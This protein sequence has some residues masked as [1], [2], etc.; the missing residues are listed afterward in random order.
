MLFRSPTPPEGFEW[1][2]DS[3]YTKTV[4][5][6][7]GNWSECISV[8]KTDNNGRD[9]FYYIKKVTET[10]IPEGTEATIGTNLVGQTSSNKALT[11]TNNLPLGTLIITK[12]VTVDGQSTAGTL[13]DGTYTFQIWNADGTSQITTKNDD[14]AIGSLLIVVKNGVAS[15][16]SITVDGL[17]PGTY[18]IKETDSTNANTMI[19]TS[20]TGYDTAKGGIVVTVTGNTNIPTAAFTNNYETI[21]ATVNKTW[22]GN[23]TPPSSLKVALVA[24]G[25]ITTP[26][27]EVTLSDSNG[28]SDTITGLP[29][30][31]NGTEIV[32]TWL[33][34]D[35][36]DGYF[37]TGSSVNGTVTALTNTYQTYGLKTSYVGIKTWSD[38]NN[39][40]STRPNDLTVTLYASYY[41]S[42]TG[43]YGD[44][45]ALTNTPTWAKD[46]AT[47]QWTYTFS[48]LPVFDENGNVIK[49]SA[50]ETQPAGYTGETTAST[51]TTYS[52]GEI[53]YQTGTGRTTPDN[54]LTWNLSSLI[55]LSFTAIKPTA[56]GAVCVWTHRV[57]TPAE[58]AAITAKIRANALPGCKDRDIV[59]YSGTGDMTTPH[60]PVHVTYNQDTLTVTLKFDEP[61]EWSQFIWGQFNAGSGSSYNIGTTS[62]TN[63]LETTS[64]SGTK[65]WSIGSDETPANPTL[66]LTRTVTTTTTVDEE[67]VTTTSS[68]ETVV[69]NGSNLQPTWATVDNK[70]TFTYSGLP[71]YDSDGNEYT[72][73]VAEASFTIG[74]GDDAVTYTVVKASDGTYTVTANKEGAA[75]FVVTQTGN[76][77][78]NN[79]LTDI[80]I[81]KVDNNNSGL[82][83][84]VFQLYVKNSGGVYELADT[85]KISGIEP[86]T[87]G[88]TTYQS[89][90][91]STGLAQTISGLAD[92]DYQFKE[93]HVPAGYINTLSSID[94][95]ISSG[96]V[97]LTTTD[98]SVSLDNTG[99]ISLITVKNTPGAA[100]PNTG[101]PGTN[102][103][104]ILGSILIL[105]AG[106]LLWRRRR[107]I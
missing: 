49:Y 59:W 20:V 26:T 17:T 65:T 98:S 16:S 62:F 83:G 78:T 3:N 2:I 60:G 67:E 46:T 102:P 34:E 84:A 50:Q 28:W 29:K 7:N 99:T 22:A 106:V 8:D 35:L 80:Q 82:E 104:Y 53:V 37:L 70:L 58:K 21:S 68:P 101:G 52:Y 93:A 87:V 86:V 44:S 97:S 54:K 103:I 38:E 81:K 63:T 61:D 94:F 74:S 105:G 91:Q 42:T 9:Y 95:T 10:G 76:D 55:D 79:S 47:N 11:V 33:E 23:G 32:Y 41:N 36:P 51:D 57:P 25:E 92:G 15:P 45:V 30:Y 100:L 6:N 90:I 73:S 43:T 18:V 40:Y 27:K 69:V 4:T 14:T 19:D 24:D 5:L 31:K 89:A 75:N 13:A 48:D 56:N 96:T 72:Y 77:I 107:L 71:K 85:T 39:K 88:D 1:Q 64:L 66:V 12:S